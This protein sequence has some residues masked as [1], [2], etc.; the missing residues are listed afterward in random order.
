MKKIIIYLLL[1]TCIFNFYLKAQEF[2]RSYPLSVKLEGG[3]VNGEPIKSG[4][5]IMQLRL[6]PQIGLSLNYE[7]LPNLNAGLY[8]AYADLKHTIKS[9]TIDGS[10]VMN[11]QIE[12]TKSN[13]MYYGLNVSYNILP[14]L[15]KTSRI[16]FDLYPIVRAGYIKEEWT[17]LD[18]GESGS[19]VLFEYGGGLGLGYNFTPL[20]GL[21]SEC[22]L[23]KYYNEGKMQFKGGLLIRF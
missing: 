18:S 4:D 22:L 21:F 6:R 3:I 20:F 7:C 10:G 2:T 12:G 5:E 13:T 23:G 8:V 1:T 16:R 9:T 14:L 11:T 15:F 19:S 17:G